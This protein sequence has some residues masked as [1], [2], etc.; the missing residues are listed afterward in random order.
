D[1]TLGPLYSGQKSIKFP[2]VPDQAGP[3]REH[4]MKA[5]ADKNGN[6]ALDPNEAVI[7]TKVKVTRI[8]LKEFRAVDTTSGQKGGKTNEAVAKPPVGTD[9]F[10][11][12]LEAPVELSVVTQPAGKEAKVKYAITTNPGN[13]GAPASGGFG[14]G[15]PVVK[16]AVPEVYYITAWVDSNDNNAQ[17]PDEPRLGVQ[18]RAARIV[19]IRASSGG[20]TVQDVDPTREQ[21]AGDIP[22]LMVC[23][24]K[25]D[26]VNVSVDYLPELVG[27]T[28]SPDA[29]LTVEAQTT[30]VR[31][32]V[33][34]VESAR[35]FT[36]RAGSVVLRARCGAREDF[37]V[38]VF[39]VDT[40]I[41]VHMDLNGNP[42]DGFEQQIVSGS[43]VQ[44][45]TVTEYEVPEPP[46]SLGAAT[47]L[48]E[49][50]VAGNTVAFGTTRVATATEVRLGVHSIRCTLTFPG[51]GRAITSQPFLL[52]VTDALFTQSADLWWFNGE[53]PANYAINVTLTYTGAAA[54]VFNWQVVQGADKV[55]LSDG[56]RD[57]NRI[58]TENSPT[59]TLKSTSPS[60]AAPTLTRDIRVRLNVNGPAAGVFATVVLAPAKLTHVS[61]AHFAVAGIPTGWVTRITYRCDDQ[62]NRVLP[63]PVPVNEQWPSRDWVSDWT[64]AA[65]RPSNENWPSP[66]EAGGTWPPSA[67]R[68]TLAAVDG[69]G[70]LVPSPMAPGVPLNAERVQHV[71]GH[72]SVGSTAAGRGVRLLS[73]I[74]WQFYRDHGSHE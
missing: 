53:S 48:W 43:T 58:V 52:T 36:D 74:R 3:T 39:V 40:T 19:A 73:D 12:C 30:G 7:S 63:A 32:Q 51:P 42:G 69:L 13:G 54:G 18:V 62:F 57:A 46:G 33:H 67:I 22:A 60:A 16:F 25:G 27:P 72:L 14:G 65:G 71:R 37:A 21:A 56:R 34:D 28:F 5:F 9:S 68:D 55:V 23:V 59:V 15:K 29:S 38:Q 1:I 11:I 4:T 66:S 41:K 70:T 20:Q 26:K 49:D 45:Y 44:Q 6:N 2:E 61:N 47:Y 17:D 64:I 31:V 24:K 8:A 10:A 35:V 50:T